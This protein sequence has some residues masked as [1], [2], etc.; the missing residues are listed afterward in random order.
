MITKTGKKSI[1]YIEKDLEPD[2]L[3]SKVDP[4][5][6]DEDQFFDFLL[7][8]QAK[9]LK[10]ESK[11]NNKFDNIRSYLKSLESELNKS[12]FNREKLITQAQNDLIENL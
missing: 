12:V 9:A 6:S 2:Y 4:K 7:V 3:V 11:I 10:I 8:A 5:N 1:K